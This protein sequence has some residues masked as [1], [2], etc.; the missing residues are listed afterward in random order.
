G[1]RFEAEGRLGRPRRGDLS[2]AVLFV[3]SAPTSLGQPSPV[4]RA[5]GGLRAG[6]R[7]ACAPLPDE[8]GG[9]LPGLVVGDTTALDPGVA[10]DFRATGMTHLCAV[11]GSNCAI[12]VGAVLVLARWCRAGPRLA[13]GLAVLALVGFV[14]LAR[15]SP[16]VLRAA[17]MAGLA[18]LALATGRQR[19]AVPALATAVTVLVVVDPGLASDL[20]F[21]LSVLATA[22]LLLLAPRMVAA[23]RQRHVPR[24]VAEMLAVPA[25]A[26]LACAPVIAAVSGTVSLVAVPANLLATPVVAPTTV[27]GVGATLLS[28]LWPAGAQYGAWLA[29]WPARWLVWIAHG[30]AAVPAGALPWPGGVRGGLLLACAGIGVWIMLRAGRWRRLLIVVTLAAVVGAVG[31]RM[32]GPSWPV[33]GWFVAVCDVGQGD[34]V[35][36]PAGRGQAVVVDAGPDPGTADACLRRLGIS[37]VPLLVISHLHADH[38]GGLPG[39]VRGRAIGR[40]VTTGERQPA[41]GSAVLREAA[42]AARAPV[43]AVGGGT[44]Y[45]VGAVRLQV[46]APSRHLGGTRSDANNNSLVVRATIGGNT[47]LLPGDAEVEQQSALLADHPR[48]LLRADV[49]KVAHHG[50]SA[51]DQAWLAAVAPAVAVVSVGRDNGF[52]HPSPATVRQ[53]VAGGARVTRTDE[54]G[55]V[56]VAASGRGRLVVAAA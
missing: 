31:G 2:A 36:L 39:I 23:L 55:S 14:I 16:S 20:G 50:S 46:L 3:R 53:L 8:V 52:G 41:A 12:V 27:L 28:P 29:S 26:Q 44:S 22:G 21:A 25:A 37:R 7:R 24:C 51:Q 13:A 6:L 49:L 32:V 54:E 47:V 43:A 34:L 4:Q 5:A 38:V 30:G 48:A 19:A 15:P 1:Q 40:I 35:V 17:A 18:L 11:S 56:A 9:L 45:T 33:R 10:D 42:R